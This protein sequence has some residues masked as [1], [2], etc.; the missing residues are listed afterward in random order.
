MRNLSAE[1]LDACF[2]IYEFNVLYIP[3]HYSV[4]INIWPCTSQSVS[5]SVNL[6]AASL[7]LA[8]YE[9]KVKWIPFR[10]LSLL[11]FSARCWWCWCTIHLAPFELHAFNVTIKKNLD[12]NWYAYTLN[13]PHGEEGKR[14][15]ARFQHIEIHT[16]QLRLN[17]SLPNDEH[18]TKKMMGHRSN[19]CT[20][21]ETK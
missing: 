1:P 3:F 15:Y 20:Y 13:L 11:L 7:C 12:K 6:C 19:I 17:E 9:L 18:Q 5:Q 4:I 21:N 2:R 16:F 14:N 10:Q 8:I